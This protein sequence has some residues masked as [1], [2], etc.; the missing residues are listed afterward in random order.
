MRVVIGTAAFFVL[1]AT[2]HAAAQPN[3]VCHFDAAMAT[4]SDESR[5]NF[6]PRGV[7]PCG[8]DG[9]TI[10]V[11]FV[12]TAAALAE[13]GGAAQIQAVATAAI[14]NV[15]QTLS[16]SGVA[17]LA[18]RSAG[19][20]AITYD[21]IA[22][23]PDAVTH[24]QRLSGTSDGF[25]DNVHALRDQNR[26][27]LVALIVATGGNQFGGAG[28]AGVN[29]PASGFSVC[30]RQSAIDG[31]F[32]HEWGHN[33]GLY[34]QC[35]NFGYGHGYRR[36][37]QGYLWTSMQG[38]P[39]A[40]AMVGSSSV[41]PRPGNVTYIP[42]YSNPDLFYLGE[43]TGIPLSQ[44]GPT[45]E[46]LAIRETHFA[47][48]NYR[49]SLDPADCNH[50]GI[51]DATDIALG[52][53]LD[54]N[55]NGKPDEC[56]IRLYVNGA[57]TVD[58]DGA[59]WTTPRRDLAE[60]LRVANLPCSNVRE[61]WVAQG[62][63]KPDGAT[64]NRALRFELP[65]SAR[66]YGGFVGNETQLSQRDFDAHP[67]ILSGE[68]G[69]PQ[70]TAD[71]TDSL[72]VGYDVGPGALLDGFTLTA[73]SSAVH[74]GAIYCEN[75]AL[76]IRNCTFTANAA[77]SFGGAVQCSLGAAPRFED[78]TFNANSAAGAG[79]GISGFQNYGLSL[80]RCTFQGHVAGWSA[81]LNLADCGGVSIDDC[82]FFDNISLD[83]TGAIEQFGGDLAVSACLFQN[84]HARTYGGA[85]TVGGAG[86][87]TLSDCRLTGNDADS[88]GGAVA[89]FGAATLQA[90][91]CTFDLNVSA[92]Q[93]GAAVVAGAAAEFRD[94]VFDNNSAAASGGAISDYDSASVLV[95]H[96][97]FIAND[98]A[99][100]GAAIDVS[101]SATLRANRCRFLGNT[102]LLDGGAI[103]ANQAAP[104]T[105]AN[106]AFS[107]NHATN[108]GGAIGLYLG[109]G[110]RVSNCTFAGNSC[111][112][113]GAALYL[114]QSAV[115]AANCAAWFDSPS[116]IGLFSGS[117]A[118]VSYSDVQGGF[119]GVGNISGNPLFA[120]RLGADGLAGTLD[121]DLT[122][123]TAS[124]CLDAGSNSE[125]SADF[126]DVD[127]DGNVAE[128]TPLDLAAAPRQ[129]DIPAAPNTG[130]GTPPVDM[131]AFERQLP[132]CP[133]DTDNDRDIDLSDLSRLL[134]N[135]GTSSGATRSMGDFDGDGDVDLSDLSSLLAN[136]GGSC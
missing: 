3:P 23:A 77:A 87:A 25:M 10:D 46:A 92:G 37:A 65:K 72:V 100:N 8:D 39:L 56:E 129:V 22:G 74:G 20:V 36:Y 130:A 17:N 40:T 11:L 42:R 125:I 121:D 43:R 31:T 49:R 120:N 99:G 115:S 6:R 44:P 29:D 101:F 88:W 24:L 85:V 63:Y 51:A 79:G 91:G 35:T 55:L 9:D 71:N 119:A 118:A 30:D 90:D 84:N 4:R 86:T 45:H 76:L 59:S 66:I 117:S 98:A 131:G 75:A 136:F 62:T 48:A 80:T 38:Q 33:L 2:C 13:A 134:A 16:A 47:V 127:H 27:D 111:T 58:G 41:C 14:A 124:P 7:D 70:T 26:A 52:V 110:H 68:I 106:S 113:A 5:T 123:N 73:G 18:F 107:G 105:V 19:V 32:T 114:W 94:C 50:N 126:A 104:I 103:F 61:I 83:F 81:A 102:A 57:A 21:E 15:N 128:V 82:Q 67:T 132:P 135:F 97:L 60:A 93:G 116:E 34:H 89:V 78:C 69:D 96:S 109:G 1:L 95:D 108:G 54:E 133:G 28:W 53:S 122:L 112:S 12:H 64:L